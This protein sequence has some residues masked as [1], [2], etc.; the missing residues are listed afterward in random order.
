M[1]LPY[2]YNSFEY[3][4]D[5]L[6]PT[7]LR[8]ISFDIQFLPS[9]QGPEHY[10]CENEYLHTTFMNG[11]VE[12]GEGS[13]F[14]YRIN[15]N[16]FRSDHFNIL[17]NENLN[18]L[19]AGCSYTFG[20]GLPEEY[21]W[22]TLLKNKIQKNSNKKVQMYNLGFM[23][24]SHINIISLVKSFIV[25]YGKPDYLFVC[26]PD[27]TRDVIYD[28]YENRYKNVI[29]LKRYIENK[30][31]YKSEFEYVKNFVY[32]NNIYR[33][34]NLIHLLEMLCEFAG[35]KLI[36]SAWNNPDA[37][38]YRQSKFKN[39]LEIDG[40][41]YPIIDE[42]LPNGEEAIR[43]ADL[44]NTNNWPYWKKARDM[45][46]PGSR[47]TNYLSDMFLNEMVNKY[48]TIV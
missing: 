46:H 16:S 15:K 24:N 18:I 26:F 44:E 27:F 39:F 17:N 8:P 2:D 37:E 40:F 31:H 45:N 25:E 30:Q 34:I 23:G 38:I 42:N 4:K 29:T 5:N 28:K 7:F 3:I 11:R 19:V 35:I 12:P 20:E 33:I 22:P 21:I 10:L 32:E 41:M 13:Y 14:Q 43:L 6:S 47:W 48:G 9:M 1:E 36:W